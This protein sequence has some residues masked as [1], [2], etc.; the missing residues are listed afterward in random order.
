MIILDGQNLTLD[1]LVF[2]ARHH[3]KVS[4][5][6][7]SIKE[8]NKA[9]ALVQEL[10]DKGK[11][12]YGINTGFGHLADV[13]IENDKLDELQVN[14]LKSHACSIG[15]PLSV[16]VVRAMITLRINALIKGYSGTR[17]ETIE[18]MVKLLN[19]NIIPVIFE[20]GSLGASGDLALLAHMGLP[21]LGLGEV[22]YK[23]Q[24]M[25]AQEALDKVNIKPL[26]KLYPKE[27]LSLI[28]GTQAM[29][30]IGALI[31]YD[32]FKLVKFVNLSLALTMEALES[33]ID[34]FDPRIQNVRK[35]LGQMEIA[36]DV[37]Q[38]L[39]GS[40][41]ITNQCTKRVQDAYSIRCAPQVHGA[42]LDVFH[43]VKNIL[44]IEMN[45]VTDNPILFVDEKQAISAGN[46]HG[47][48]LALAFD[49]LAMAISEL[50]NISERRIERLVNPKLN[51]GLPPFLSSHS[52]VNSGFMIV[53]YAAASIVSE[54]KVYA[55]PASVDS[56][57][58][59]ANQ[60]DHV[61]MGATSA[62]KA[63]MILENTRKVIA[64]EMFTAAQA[65]HFRGKDQLGDKTKIA[66]DYISS[67]I[68][69]IKTDEV[70][71]PYIHQVES[72]LEDDTFYHLLFKGDDDLV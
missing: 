13:K 71:Y 18:L 63:R 47:Q 68:P 51:D 69:F 62:R 7:E 60:E 64:L 12:I 17:L 35:H 28:N 30:A 66:F 14:L 38:F 21:L 72:M 58:S 44:D 45:S 37:K 33:I 10:V 53:Q 5:S 40:K 59:S 19:E 15:N 16:E 55:H 57:P 31:L 11:P 27:G 70:M 39:M 24:R 43:H 8:I 22:Y 50:A 36:F 9:S 56:I 34:A 41:N 6:K 67:Q 23:N 2:I 29:T 52:G 25:P 54:N 1:D 32:A 46:F 65:L 26:D 4:I 3:E 61:S 49:Y 48:P 42:S 20:Q